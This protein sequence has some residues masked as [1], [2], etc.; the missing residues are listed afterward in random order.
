MPF[1]RGS[2]ELLAYTIGIT[3]ALGP[4]GGA[5]TSTVYVGV[6]T[7]ESE[8]DEIWC[9]IVGYEC[10]SFPSSPAAAGCVAFSSCDHEGDGGYAIESSFSGGG[11]V[12]WPCISEEAEEVAFAT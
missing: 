12:P 11:D 1:E 10:V 2:E 5:D 6:A 4:E 3:V 9:S 7:C 8:I